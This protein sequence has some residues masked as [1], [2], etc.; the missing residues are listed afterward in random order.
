MLIVAHPHAQPLMHSSPYDSSFDSIEGD[1]APT[2]PGLES[3]DID[4]SSQRS[5]SVVSTSSASSVTTTSSLSSST[6]NATIPASSLSTQP[7]APSVAQPQEPASSSS[8]SSLLLGRLASS[9]PVRPSPLQHATTSQA[10]P[11]GGE[12]APLSRR[13]SQASGGHLD[14]AL[15]GT[16]AATAHVGDTRMSRRLSEA[17]KDVKPTRRRSLAEEG[18]Q[19]DEG[20]EEDGDDAGD[21]DEGDDDDDDE[22]DEDDEDDDDEMDD[23]EDGDDEDQVEDIEEDEEGDMEDNEVDKA[24][25]RSIG[26]NSGKQQGRARGN[27]DGTAAAGEDDDVDEQ[28]SRAVSQISEAE[29]EDDESGVE[30]MDRDDSERSRHHQA[31]SG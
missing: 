9:L 16:T 20:A 17:R 21:E 12:E 11:R 1:S 24:M 13:A 31:L 26:G 25:A 10:N 6:S 22:D 19:G 5:M 8:S 29:D 18:E 3:D 14:P 27:M 7:L 15:G 23:E 2:S 28:P 30:P 4:P